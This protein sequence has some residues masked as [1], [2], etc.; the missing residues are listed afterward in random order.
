MKK[1]FSLK[2]TAEFQT[3]FQKKCSASDGLLVLYVCG[4]DS[5]DDRL[6]VPRGCR[7]GLSVSKRYGGAVR[8]VRWKRLV[9][10]AFRQISSDLLPELDCALDIV[11]VPGR[12]RHSDSMQD[13]EKTFRKLLPVVVKKWKRGIIAQNIEKES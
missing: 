8:R 3:V 13:F 7:L 2:K 11:V 6:D 1:T 9:R 12:T 10:A 5:S 4:R